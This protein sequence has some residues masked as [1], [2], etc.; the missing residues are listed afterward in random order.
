MIRLFGLL[1][2]GIFVT[3]LI[4][5]EDHGQK[6][7]GLMLAD[8]QAAAAVAPVAET[9]PVD[10]VKAV[11]IPAQPVIQPIE[12]AVRTAVAAATATAATD[13]GAAQPD[14]TLPAPEIP[15]GT[16]FTVAA[17]GANVRQGPGMRFAVLD[18]LTVGE[19]VLVIA[20]DPP[21]DGWSR[22]RLE[23]DGVEGFI[24]TKLLRQSE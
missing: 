10:E 5:G 8:Q 6:R 18:S 2:I 7:Y 19:Q 3:L 14:H 23:G 15:G 4:A 24:A 13:P 1:C 16:L 9:T 22:V 17:R 11:F 20:Q 21:T 12:A